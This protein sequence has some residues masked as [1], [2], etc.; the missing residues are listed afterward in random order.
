[1]LCKRRII[2][3]PL[4]GKHV[5]NYYCFIQL[6]PGQRD[7]DVADRVDQVCMYISALKYVDN[8]LGI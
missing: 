6:L 5:R 3:I 7:L 1:M 8:E 4:G 2:Q